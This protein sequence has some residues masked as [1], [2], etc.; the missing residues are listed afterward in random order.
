MKIF[1]IHFPGVLRLAGAP[2][3]NRPSSVAEYVYFKSPPKG[4]FAELASKDTFKNPDFLPF[5]GCCFTYRNERF[6]TRDARQTAVNI[7]IPYSGSYFCRRY[8]IRY[9]WLRGLPVTCL[10]RSAARYRCP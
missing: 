1:S 9:S 4:N 10:T 5:P 6:F 7:Q 8:L 3:L 2:A